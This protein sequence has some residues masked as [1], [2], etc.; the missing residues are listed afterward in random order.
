MEALDLV[1][2]VQ[3]AIFDELV[4]QRI[5]HMKDFEAEH[6]AFVDV[7]GQIVDCKELDES[8]VFAR[9]CRNFELSQLWGLFQQFKELLK[10]GFGLFFGLIGSFE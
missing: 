2:F 1:S 10:L 6:N 3:W 4:G 5:A 8:L 9:F 7:S